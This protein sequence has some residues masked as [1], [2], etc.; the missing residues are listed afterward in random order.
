MAAILSRPQCVNRLSGACINHWCRVVWSQSYKAFITQFSHN[1]SIHDL[2][3]KSHQLMLQRMLTIMQPKQANCI[4]QG[5]EKCENDLSNISPI[6]RS[7]FPINR[8]DE[9]ICVLLFFYVANIVFDCGQHRT[10]YSSIIQVGHSYQ[11]AYQI[12]LLLIRDISVWNSLHRRSTFTRLP[13]LA[14]HSSVSHR[15]CR[16]VS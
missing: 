12:A 7:I 16:S 14:S 15:N 3:R 13:L 10:R 1:H 6:L 8:L 4:R 2:H 9:F 11:Q 5:L